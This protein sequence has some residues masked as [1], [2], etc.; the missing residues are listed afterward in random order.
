MLQQNSNQGQ[1][2]SESKIEIENS[3]T[4]LSH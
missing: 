2:K 4:F 3:L 1:L